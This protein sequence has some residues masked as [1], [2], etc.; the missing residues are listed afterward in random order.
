[1]ITLCVCVCVTSKHPAT[2]LKVKVQYDTVMW[3]SDITLEP[4]KESPRRPS[5]MSG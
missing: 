4:M 5:Q 2:T 3:H 1:M